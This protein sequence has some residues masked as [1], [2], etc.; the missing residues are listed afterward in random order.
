MKKEL[1]VGM[2]LP[3]LL[4]DMEELSGSGLLLGSCW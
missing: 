1:S 4:L 2:G 3:F